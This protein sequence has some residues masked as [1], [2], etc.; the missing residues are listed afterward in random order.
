VRPWL[1]GLA[2]LVALA[3][4]AVLVEPCNERLPCHRVL[5]NARNESRI[6]LTTS[7]VTRLNKPGPDNARRVV[8][9]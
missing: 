5:F 2:Y 9:R 7:Q 4:L 8:G 1:E 6:M 3:G